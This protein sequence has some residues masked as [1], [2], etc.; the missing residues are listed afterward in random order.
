MWSV[1]VESIKILVSVTSV[2]LLA[3]AALL[4]LG[5]P[6]EA[7]GPA[8]ISQLVNHQPWPPILFVGLVI[9]CVVDLL[10]LGVVIHHRLAVL[11]YARGLNG[12][13]KIFVGQ[14]PGVLHPA[15]SPSV[16][17]WPFP[18]NVL[19]PPDYEPLGPMG[20]I[21][22]ASAVVNGIYAFGSACLITRCYSSA[23]LGLAVTFGV[24]EFWYYYSC[25]RRRRPIVGIA[26]AL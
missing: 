25:R 2:P 17:N 11:F 8:F 3:A 15:G 14:L 10:L 12:Y 19:Y 21:V 6:G 5:K 23:L 24:F 7:D 18:T 9:I 4:A 1:Y 26:A 20:L 13:R 22:H 16:V